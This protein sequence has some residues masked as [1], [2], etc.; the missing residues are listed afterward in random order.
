MLRSHL[1]YLA[2]VSYASTSFPDSLPLRLLIS[3]I[4]LP[5]FFVRQLGIMTSLSVFFFFFS[6]FFLEGKARYLS[7]DRSIARQAIEPVEED[8]VSAMAGNQIDGWIRFIVHTEDFDR[9]DELLNSR[10]I[11]SRAL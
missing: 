8:Q 4:P 1:L 3:T 2:S 6:S 7:I 5:L 11:R 9:H 10:I